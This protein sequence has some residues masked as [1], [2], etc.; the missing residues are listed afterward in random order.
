MKLL[1]IGVAALGL[2]LTAATSQASIVL[3][4]SNTQN[5]GIEFSGSPDRTFS[6]Y[7]S[8]SEFKIT[9]SSSASQSAVDLTGYFT[10]TWTIGTIVS[11]PTPAGSYQIAPVTGNGGMLFISDNNGYTLSAN[12][13]WV[14]ISSSGT[15]GNANISG[16]INLS[17]INYDG[18]N[19]DL[20]ELA[21][22][23]NGVATL[24]YTF[25]SIV[26]LTDLTTE[27]GSAPFSGKISSTTPVPEPTTI[28]A[29]ALLLLPFGMGVFRSLRK[30]R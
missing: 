24:S 17:N 29:G 1:S 3:S 2:A 13:S 6:F 23:I 30:N 27:G 20:V 8:T 25:N 10:G 19:A 22:D 21:S 11:T 28:I 18:V 14:N 12:V 16:V 9:S 7:D 26:T 15:G 4:F 5:S